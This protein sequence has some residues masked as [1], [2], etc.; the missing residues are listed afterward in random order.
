MSLDTG[1]SWTWI[2]EKNCFKDSKRSLFDFWGLLS[3]KQKNKLICDEEIIEKK[4]ISY[5]DGDFNGD[6][7]LKD[8]YLENSPLSPPINLYLII[9]KS[10]SKEV[11]DPLLGIFNIRIS[12][13]CWKIS[14]FYGKFKDIKDNPQ[15]YIH[16]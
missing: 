5:L 8:I 12:T 11:Q 3:S 16:I 7:I 6:I 15:K 4:S 14:K 13:N 10:E 2:F 9:N 1:S